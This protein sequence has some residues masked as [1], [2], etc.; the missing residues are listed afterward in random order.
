MK[1]VM[2]EENAREATKHN[3]INITLYHSYHVASMDH[4]K[5]EMTKRIHK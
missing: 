3:K 1:R 2:N 5:E 4:D